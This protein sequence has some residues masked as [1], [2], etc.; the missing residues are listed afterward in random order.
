[1]S[2]RRAGQA[3]RSLCQAPHRGLSTIRDCRRWHGEGEAV[4]GGLPCIQTN[5]AAR[6]H[7]D[8]QS[9]PCAALGATR[10]IGKT[11][12]IPGAYPGL[13]PASVSY[14]SQMSVKTGCGCS[15]EGRQEC[16][17]TS[18]GQRLDGRGAGCHHQAHPSQRT[19][20]PI[21]TIC[22]PCTFAVL[23]RVTGVGRVG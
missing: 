3:I 21:F 17:D 4:K 10:G 2:G 12:Q 18:G 1:M 5:G 20:P 22:P 6:R 16:V 11:A 13:A 14:A 7:R 23:T 8:M 19:S 15:W 9:K